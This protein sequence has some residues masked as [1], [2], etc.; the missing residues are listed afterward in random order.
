M[1]NAKIRDLIDTIQAVD[2]ASIGQAI[3]TIKARR[4]TALKEYAAEI[5]TLNRLRR[6]I[7]GSA[8]KSKKRGAPDVAAADNQPS[9]T[10][11]VAAALKTM[12]SATS[13]EIAEHIGR[14]WRGVKAVLR[15]GNGSKFRLVG[16]KEEDVWELIPQEK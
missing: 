11:L 8:K 1:D 13:K 12:D 5:A 15:F 14:E 6:M 16:S 3:Q 10:A 9:P 7:G 2:L 4:Q